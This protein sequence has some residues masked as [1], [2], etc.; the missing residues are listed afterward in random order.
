[1]CSQGRKQLS[2]QPGGKGASCLRRLRCRAAPARARSSCWQEKFAA[3]LGFFPYP[4][5]ASR[6]KGFFGDLDGQASWAGH[7]LFSLKDGETDF[8]HQL[9]PPCPVAI[10]GGCWRHMLVTRCANAPKRHRPS[11]PSSPQ[12]QSRIWQVMLSKAACTLR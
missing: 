4:I 2:I 1:M 6:S 3:G 12:A 7:W 8:L 5:P 11:P 10:P 9:L